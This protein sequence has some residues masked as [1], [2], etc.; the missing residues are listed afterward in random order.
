[1]DGTALVLCCGY[2]GTTNGKTAHGLVRGTGRYRVLGVV[3]APLAGRDAGEALDGK[4]RD[5]PIFGS[6][7][8]ALERLGGKPDYAVVGLATHGGRLTPPVKEALLEAIESGI[9][10]VNG[11]H[12]FAAEDPEIAAAAARR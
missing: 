1:M 11:L 10:V 4:R 7:A 9:S 3:D 2:Y 6:L 5:I 12:E 8:E